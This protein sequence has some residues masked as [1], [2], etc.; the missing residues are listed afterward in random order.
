MNNDIKIKLYFSD[1]NKTSPIMWKEID[2]MIS[3][4]Y[5]YFSLRGFTSI[6]KIKNIKWE[7]DYLIISIEIL[8]KSI[9]LNKLEAQIKE[10][11]SRAFGKF[12]V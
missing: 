4:M 7:F 3:D 11:F 10:E 6:C 5:K 2:K 9:D 1:K 8:K 12:E